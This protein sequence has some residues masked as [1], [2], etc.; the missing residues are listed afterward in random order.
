MQLEVKIKEDIL[1]PEDNDLE[2]QGPLCNE[3]IQL[4]KAANIYNDL[5]NEITEM[6]NARNRFRLDV[7]VKRNFK[8][9]NLIKNIWNHF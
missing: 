9:T 6:E 2:S 7:F 3:F 8:Q 1:I 5:A 4:C